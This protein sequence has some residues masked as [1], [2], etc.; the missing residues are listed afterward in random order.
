MKKDYAARRRRADARPAQLLWTHRTGDDRLLGGM[1][2]M[3]ANH[4]GATHGDFTD[5]AGVLTI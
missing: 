2:G 1:P 4:G 3:G 5:R